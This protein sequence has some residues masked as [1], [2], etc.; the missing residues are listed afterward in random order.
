MTNM[1]HVK[2][3]TRAQTQALVLRDD[4]YQIVSN[5]KSGLSANLI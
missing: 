1:V 3:R 5:P 2:I 4:E